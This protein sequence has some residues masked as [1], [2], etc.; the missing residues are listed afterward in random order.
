MSVLLPVSTFIVGLLARSLSPLLSFQL[1]KKLIE[2]LAKRQWRIGLGHKL[3]G[4]WNH[5]WYA[6][7]SKNWPNENI[8]SIAMSSIGNCSAGVYE[9]KGKQWL[10]TATLVAGNIIEGTWR[11][12][13]DNG[14]RGTWLGSLDNNNKQITGWYLGTSDRSRTSVGEWVWWREGEQKPD[15]PEPLIQRAKREVLSAADNHSN[16]VTVAGS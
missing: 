10:V 11:D 7:G 9:Y 5:A 8:C 16:A 3:G 6:E 12:L 4:A 14:Y 15:L 2:F 13:T 1:Q